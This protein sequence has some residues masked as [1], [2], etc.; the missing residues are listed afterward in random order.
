[1]LL[2]LDKNGEL[3]S[4]FRV[5]HQTHAHVVLTKEKPGA[6]Y[7]V[8]IV[9]RSTFTVFF[10]SKFYAN[11]PLLTFLLNFTDTRVQSQA[12]VCVRVRVV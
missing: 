10:L 6:F 4:V 11:S 9:K 5:N 3:G 7:I 2:R 12:R 1:M 8:H